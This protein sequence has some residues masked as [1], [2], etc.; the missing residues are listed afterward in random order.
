LDLLVN[1]KLKYRG[2]LATRGR[3]KAFHIDEIFQPTD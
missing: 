2:S 3:K 1:G